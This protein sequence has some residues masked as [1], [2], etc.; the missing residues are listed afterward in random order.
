MDDEWLAP[1][2]RSQAKEFRLFLHSLARQAGGDTELFGR[3][4]KREN[5]CREANRSSKPCRQFMY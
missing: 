1:P 4:D 3:D 2:Y 5:R